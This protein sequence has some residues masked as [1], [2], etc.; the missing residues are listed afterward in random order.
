[1]CPRLQ[2][3][4]AVCHPKQPQAT[5]HCTHYTLKVAE[6]FISCFPQCETQQIEHSKALAWVG[7]FV[8]DHNDISRRHYTH[9]RNVIGAILGAFGVSIEIPRTLRVQH[10]PQFPK[11]FHNW[12]AYFCSATR[13]S[14]AAVVEFLMVIKR[15]AIRTISGVICVNGKQK[16]MRDISMYH[17]WLHAE[18]FDDPE[19][20]LIP[21]L[22]R[23]AIP[24]QW[25]DHRAAHELFRSLVHKSGRD[26]GQGLKKLILP[27]FWPVLSWHS[28]PFM[29][30]EWYL[31]VFLFFF[32]Q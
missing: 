5:S 3:A 11:H 7:A 30:T 25:T 8:R 32:T 28:N 16:R 20:Q 14:E 22:V 31:L 9:V 21:P 2:Q 19:F 1:M 29:Y 12:V 4:V 24:I 15:K 6:S 26:K 10:E 17:H 27:L 13:G 23:A 18:Y